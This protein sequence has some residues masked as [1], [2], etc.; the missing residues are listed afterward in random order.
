MGLSLKVFGVFAVR[1]GSGTE[2]SL[3]TRKTRALLGYLAVNA[4]KPQPRERLM[5]L[6]WS[7]RD[8]RQARQSL[9][10]AL[11]SIR[12]L[13]S[14]E[15]PTILDSDGEQVTLHGAAL[16][17]DVARFR[18]L[19]ADEPA[20]AAN[21]YDGPL[22][23]GL[24]VPD[25]AFEDWLAATRSELHTTACDA[26]QRA[27]DAA[28]GRGDTREAIDAARRLVALD[29]LREGGHRLM[30]LML[31]ESGDRAGALR[32]YQFCADIL[33]KE[34]QVE[35]D[36]ATRAL[37]KEITRET[38]GVPKVP[39]HALE[40]PSS[41]KSESLR[42]QPAIAVLPLNNLS[43]EPG[44]EY[45]AD[46]MTEDIITALSRLRWFLVIA[47]NSTFVYKHKA[48]NIKQIAHELDVD[49]VLEGSVRKSGNR[50]RVSAQLIDANSGA[51]LWAQ[52]YDRQLTDIF[53]LQDDITQ[54]V[55]AAIE[56]QL[57][58]AEGLRTQKRS[59]E[60]LNAWQLVM[61]GL[62]YLGRMN[63][64]ESLAAI[65][66]LRSAVRQYPD[67]GPAHS[68]LAFVLLISG[69]VGWTTGGIG[70]G[71]QLSDDLRH[72]AATLARRALQLDYDDPWAHFALGNCCFA[73]RR[74]EEA[75]REYEKAIDLNPNFAIAYGSL[76]RA[77]V[78][79]GQYEDAIRYFQKAF[80]MSP[81]DPLIAV[82][83]SGMCTANYYAHRY[84]EAIEWGRKAIRE[85][86]GY[87]AAHRI[88]CASLAMAGR[89]EDTEAAVATLRQLQPDI[90]IAW[91]EQY[92]PYTPRAMPHFLD[93]MYKAGFK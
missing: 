29:P 7:D 81:H 23:D 90:S 78:F 37:F 11:K 89:T 71:Y 68:L 24:S 33:K 38:S 14:G 18:A 2:L 40:I 8:E 27:A 10:D 67:Y 75:V 76:G 16:E 77:L 5:A 21:L 30:M 60:D 62:T 55:T 26:L 50:I 54:R 6:L 70:Y 74:T 4:D 44:Q 86:P 56:P 20:E 31:Y 51:H 9:N 22:L 80:R 83:Y 12:R 87:T 73:E 35:P 49:Y 41:G 53:E 79:D 32:Q 34:L 82:F 72:E 15:G 63:K 57:M 66:L 58:V 19:L 85:R 3:R 64:N 59:P 52:N 1:D 39:P 25:P 46:G 36:V 84:D 92:V 47:R 88:L 91:V 61:R 13:A 28:A 65:E 69:Q 42:D 17:I 93:G 43:A 45:F 48:I